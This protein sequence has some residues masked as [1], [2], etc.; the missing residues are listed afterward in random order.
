MLGALAFTSSPEPV[1]TLSGVNIAKASRLHGQLD[2]GA[3]V[4]WRGRDLVFAKLHLKLVAP[5]V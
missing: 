1:P 2:A 4:L 5:A 3:N